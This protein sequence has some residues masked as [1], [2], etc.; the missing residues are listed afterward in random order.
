M[1]R[2]V[3]EGR[4]RARFGLLKNRSKTG[5]TG[6]DRFLVN[7]WVKFAIFKNLKHFE[8]KILKN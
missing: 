8:I 2:R 4:A 3:G 1:N 6:P 7:R 5:V